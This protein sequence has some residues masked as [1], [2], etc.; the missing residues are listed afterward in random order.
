[1]GTVLV[2]EDDLTQRRI[3]SKV[4]TSIGLDMIF[5]VDGVEALEL[6]ESYYPDLVVLDIIMPRMNGYEVCRRLKSSKK[7]QNIAVLMYSNK[8]EECDFYWGSKQGADAYASK[9]CSPQELVNTIRY[10]LQIQ[11]S[12]GLGAGV[13]RR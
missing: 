8:G 12:E 5:A 13:R 7:T 11:L 6:V 9:L 3:L 4:L 1:M 2:V 10:L